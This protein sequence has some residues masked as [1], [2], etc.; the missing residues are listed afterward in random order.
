MRVGGCSERFNGTNPRNWNRR[1]GDQ[2][3]P[4]SPPLFSHVSKWDL[5]ST[6]PRASLLTLTTTTS[7]ISLFSFTSRLPPFAAA[8]HRKVNSYHQ[9]YTMS[10]Q[11][12]D[13]AHPS[14]SAP[15]QERAPTSSNSVGDMPTA[16]SLLAN[17]I[18]GKKKGKKKALTKKV[19]KRA[20]PGESV[21]DPAAQRGQYQYDPY[22][23][24]GPTPEPEGSRPADP[25][26]LDTLNA[27]ARVL[28]KSDREVLDYVEALNYRTAAILEYANR[29]GSQLRSSK[30]VRERIELYVDQLQETGDRGAHQQPSGDAPV[31]AKRKSGEV[32]ASG[33]DESLDDG[34]DAPYVGE[35][36]HLQM[37]LTSQQETRPIS[38]AD[39]CVQRE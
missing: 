23:K 34:D 11:G 12:F 29:T 21:D 17:E 14:T 2:P 7:L 1:R 33:S 15:A 5:A 37:C 9:T 22:R 19:A 30:G 18:A 36:P 38:H 27:T 39:A 3:W 6:I 28:F 26:E 31:V 24:A 35:P 16:D 13:P 25:E 8:R 10:V 32:E 4:T 20:E